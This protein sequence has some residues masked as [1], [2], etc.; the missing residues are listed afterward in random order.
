VDNFE[1]DLRSLSLIDSTI[2]GLMALTWRVAWNNE[3]H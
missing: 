1:S 3:G 2:C